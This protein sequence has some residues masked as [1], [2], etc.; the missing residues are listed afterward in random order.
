MRRK[1]EEK[2]VSPIATNNSNR[3]AEQ[4]DSTERM[5]QRNVD[6]F[7]SLQMMG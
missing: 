2:T 7:D 1:A 6:M 5:Q 3:P 4:A